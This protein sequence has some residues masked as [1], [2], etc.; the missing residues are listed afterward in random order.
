MP[1]KPSSL[2]RAKKFLDRHPLVDGHNDL[3]WVI[4]HDAVARGDVAAYGL[5]RLHQESDTDIPRLKEGKVAAQF[6]AAFVATEE[7]EPTIKTFEQIA[8]I[9]RMNALHADV[10]LPACRSSDI[11]RAK[12]L[13]KIASFI[14]VEGGV[15]L[16]GSLE[17]LEAFYG[18]G[19][20]Y[21]TLCHNGTLAW[22]DSSTDAARN[23]GLTDFG[24]AVV[25]TMN[26]LGMIV[27]C[28]HVS[29]DAARQVLDVSAAP[30]LVT[31]ANARTLC[32]HPRNVPDDVLDRIAA[33]GGAVMATFVPDF[34]NPA[35]L[36]WHEPIQEAIRRSKTSQ[37]MAE[38]ERAHTAAHGPA[39]PATI[40]HVCDHIEYMARRMGVDHVG[41]GSDYFGG[42]TPRGLEDVS[43]FPHL[44]AALMDRGWGDDALAKLAGGN[45]IRVFRDVEKVARR[46]KRRALK[47]A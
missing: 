4:R 46:L 16:G 7:P 11:A 8:L 13:G 34:L 37:E 35:T 12:R 33:Q 24:R 3:P 9:R 15:G 20:R 40:N 38:V 1:A 10:F 36:A 6:W 42:S 5:D 26:T 45:V 31:H 47:E 41:I 21:M 23:G 17:V 18:L 2:D 32:D 39:P 30:I 27:D 28:A 44:I 43:R 29:P 22:V 25:R 14:S 19:V